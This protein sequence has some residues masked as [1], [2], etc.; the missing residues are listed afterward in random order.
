MLTTVPAELNRKLN[1]VEEL[2][3]FAEV[4]WPANTIVLRHGSVAMIPGKSQT[5][6]YRTCAIISSSLILKSCR[7]DEPVL[8]EKPN[9][10][11]Y[12]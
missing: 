4:S 5:L 10:T 11:R 9:V 6:Y 12:V 7:S 1:G 8:T 2:T 3:V